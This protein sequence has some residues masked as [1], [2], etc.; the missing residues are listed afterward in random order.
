M[1]IESKKELLKV[2]KQRRYLNKDFDS[3][4]QDLTNYAK[5]YFPNNI[6]DFSE[7]SLAGMFIELASYIGDVDSFYLDHQ[8]HELN[9]ETAVETRNIESMIKR[10]G[11]PIVGASPSVLTQTFLIEVPATGNPPVPNPIAIPITH[12]GTIVAAENGT[13][14]ELI[15]DIDYSETDENGEYKAEITIGNI[16]SNGNPTTFIMSRTGLCISGFRATES[17]S[18]GTFE[19]FKQYTLT[20]ENVTDI[21]SVTDSQGNN[22]YQVEYLTDDTVFKS[23]VNKNTNDNK[24]VKEKLLVIP[25]PYRFISEMSLQTRL[26]NLTFGGGSAQSMNDDIIPDPSEFAIP[27]YGKKVFS[28]FSLNP[29]NLLQTTTLGII[30]PNS[31]ITIVYRYGGGLSHN[32]GPQTIR[33]ISTLKMSFPNGPTA[34]IAQIVKSS[35][36]TINYKESSGGEDA[37]TVNELKAR[38]PSAKA[39]QNRIVTKEDLIARLYTMPS[40]FGRVFRASVG[41]DPNNP[42]SSRVYIISRNSDSQL[43]LSPDSLKENLSTYLNR[44]RM[45]NDSLDILDARI[46]N[47]QLYFSIVADPSFGNK[48]LIKQNVLEKI[49]KYFNIKN[50]EIDQPIFI[51]EIQNIIYNIPGVLS[52]NE[53]RIE[54]ITGTVNSNVDGA[55]PRI[56]SNEQYDIKSNTDKN[57]IYLPSGGI[58][59]LKYPDHDLKCVVLS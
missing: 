49:K 12:E 8:F 24:I 58:F 42:L 41:P 47:I 16:D 23:I 28:R 22:Y 13:Q 1:T 38:I 18:V 51:N 21:I 31:T 52:V 15:E 5:N 57:I 7:T 14:F 50:F 45:S 10:A 35:A 27:L 48:N 37:P 32:V 4:K 53:I 33:T 46:I 19:Q 29:S 36:D 17:F 30:A 20:Q 40:N 54:N 55:E 39:S 26:T 2:L 56:Y 25:A 34:E 43:I 11:V 59:E 44:F 6:K 9:P 3:F